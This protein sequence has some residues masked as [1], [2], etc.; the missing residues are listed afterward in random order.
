MNRNCSFSISTILKAKK[1]MPQSF[2]HKQN[3]N[4]RNVQ[5]DIS[6]ERFYNASAIFEKHP[7]GHVNRLMAI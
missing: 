5:S 4:L 2:Q 3:F 7:V 6:F 1:K